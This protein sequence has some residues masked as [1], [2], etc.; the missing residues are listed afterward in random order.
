VPSSSEDAP[1]DQ[2][3]NDSKTDRPFQPGVALPHQQPEYYR[4]H[5]HAKNEVASTT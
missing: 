1:A 4:Y 5:D 3:E 2:A